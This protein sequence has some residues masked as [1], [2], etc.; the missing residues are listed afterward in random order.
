MLGRLWQPPTQLYRA[1]LGVR[2]RKA[3]QYA[4]RDQLDGTSTVS[5]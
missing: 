1:R 2:F 5:R 4:V 3:G